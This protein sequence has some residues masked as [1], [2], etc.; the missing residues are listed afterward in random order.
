MDK[1]LV[2]P[3]CRTGNLYVVYHATVTY[4]PVAHFDRHSNEMDFAGGDK[5]VFL[6]EVSHAQC[7]ECDA[8]WE[9]LPDLYLEFEG[10]VK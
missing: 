3:R 6:K 1:P 10:V 8:E 4:G 7:S 2:C 9:H 5:R